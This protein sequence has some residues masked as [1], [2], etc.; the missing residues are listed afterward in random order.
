MINPVLLK[1]IKA[2]FGSDKKL[3][4]VLSQEDAIKKSLEYID[5]RRNGTIKSIE[6]GFKQL[7][8]VTMNGLETNKIFTIAAP[9][10]HGKSMLSKRL[11]ND[12]S[13]LNPDVK[14][15]CFGFE[16]EA[17]EQI[18]RSIASD[19]KITL[20]NLYS[21]KSKLTD[22][23][24]H[25]VKQHLTK[26]ANNKVVYVENPDTP[27]VIANTVMDYWIK[28]CAEKSNEVLIVE[29]DHVLLTKGK[30]GQTEKGKIDELFEV[31]NGLKQTIASNGGKILFIELSQ[32]NRSIRNTSNN[33]M[34]QELREPD[35]ED[36]FGSSFIE[37]FSHYIMFQYIP[38]KLRLESYTMDVYPTY[39]KHRSKKKEWFDFRVPFV[40]HHIRKNRSGAVPD[41]PA[42]YLSDLKHFDIKELT[43]EELTWYR[44]EFA[45]KGEILIEH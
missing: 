36:L 22:D 10:S 45:S 28:E 20:S 19:L 42:I 44:T 12:I 8:A 38:L 43:D 17:R 41:S 7:N 6:T 15:L 25:T 1:S 18:D 9:S 27:I 24:Y 4:E 33:S 3:M 26:L 2:K 39:V 32:M 30:D 40:F 11:R 29:I 37:Q 13:L 16:M 31:T 5:G 34:P 21:V 23:S 35:V 14:Q